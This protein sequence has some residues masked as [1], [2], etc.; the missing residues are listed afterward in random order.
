MDN[1]TETR[2]EHKVRFF[3]HVHECEETPDLIG[4]SLT[5]HTIDFSMHGLKLRCD[6]FLPEGTMVNITIGIGDPFTLY[7][8]R[9][10]VRW[11]RHDADHGDIVMGILL[12][13]AEGTDFESW[14]LAFD[15]T[16]NRE[17]NAGLA[18]AEG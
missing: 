16:F 10:E 1:R 17:L 2:I 13:E 8:L 12:G 11:T 7:L 9:G 15:E 5:C 4:S 3:V 18:N 14:F 6:E